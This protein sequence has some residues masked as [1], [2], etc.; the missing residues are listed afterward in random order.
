ML[1]IKQ[2]KIRF[3][4]HI[5]D[6]EQRKLGEVVSKQIKGKTKFESLESGNVEYLD[7]ARLNG[8]IPILTNALN[9]VETDD[10]IILWDGSKAGTVYTG[11]SG[12]LGSTLKAY[13]TNVN[14]QFVYQ[15]LKLHQE[16]IYN[17]YR[18]PNIPHVQKDFLDVFNINVPNLGEQQKIGDFFKTL[19]DTITL[20]QQKLEVTK[21]FKQTMLKKMFPKNGET[22]PE[23]RFKGFTDDWCVFKVGDIFNNVI[24]SGNRLP[25]DSLV[26][27]DIPYVIAK[28]ENNGVFKH[29]SKDTLDFNGNIMKLFNKNSITLSI[30]NPEAIFVQKE[31]FYTSN[32]MRVLYNEE[33]T[34]EHHLIISEK[35]KEKTRG[36]G[37]GLKFSGPIIM[38]TELI[39]PTDGSKNI[40]I[41]ELQIIGKLFKD[42]DSQIINLE[43]KIKTIKTLKATLLSKI[44]I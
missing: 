3:K 4:G 6:W 33:L 1:E 9:D 2:P 43:N 44:F 19:D 7:T 15:F 22:T 20:H 8:G 38:N 18:T 21:Q 39:L 16:N 36:F 12:A 14:G 27:G 11:F 30:D 5:N 23:I 25:K 28:S 32:I 34:Y 13:K 37:W 31:N 24:L 29:I 17:N 41:Y 40:G 10:I 35:I 42:I 26:V